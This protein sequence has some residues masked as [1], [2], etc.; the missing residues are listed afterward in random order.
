MFAFLRFSVSRLPVTFAIYECHKPLLQ[1]KAENS[2]FVRDC[3]GVTIEGCIDLFISYED[4]FNYDITDSILDS[5]DTDLG[6]I[7]L[8]DDSSDQGYEYLDYEYPSHSEPFIDDYALSHNASNYE[9]L[10]LITL[11]KIK[12]EVNTGDVDT[13]DPMLQR[14]GQIY[15]VLANLI[16]GFFIPFLAIMV[17]NLL[18]AC[19][20]RGRA[21][22]RLE[23]DNVEEESLA[24]RR[25]SDFLRQFSHHGFSRSEGE[26]YKKGSLVS[27]DKSHKPNHVCSRSFNQNANGVGA[28]SQFKT[29][30]T[31]IKFHP[32][33]PSRSPE[34]MPIVKT[35]E[36]RVRLSSLS[37]QFRRTSGGSGSSAESFL[38]DMTSLHTSSSPGIRLS[39][40]LFVQTQ[41]GRVSGSLFCFY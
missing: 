14:D 28:E 6:L 32:A 21:M 39:A 9:L 15:Q 2:S 30:S 33:S 35:R 27:N 3:C 34:A 12:I 19:I 5:N 40:P 18:I 22:S 7:E 11:D 38:T 20:I 1:A 29:K 24:G 23:S 10:Y 8:G 25:M 13:C 31:A 37:T 17:S 4:R 16:I 41:D 36:P 26:S